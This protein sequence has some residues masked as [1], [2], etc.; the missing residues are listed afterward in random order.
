MMRKD[1]IENPGFD[2][3]QA[4][5]IAMGFPPETWFE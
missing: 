2:K 1:K 3:L 5:A 4:I